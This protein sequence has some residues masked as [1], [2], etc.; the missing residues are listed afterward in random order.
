MVRSRRWE[1]VDVAGGRPISKAGLQPAV[2]TEDGPVPDE[3]AGD[4]LGLLPIQGI[5]DGADDARAIVG[6]HQGDLRGVGDRDGV[7]EI[8][9][10]LLRE[11]AGGGCLMHDGAGEG[12]D[13][14]LAHIGKAEGEQEEPGLVE[15][16]VGGIGR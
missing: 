7:V 5:D 2:G 6:D 16:H 14:P 9:E 1:D 10:R 4:H 15:L 8:H 13:I 11:F 3:R 12:G